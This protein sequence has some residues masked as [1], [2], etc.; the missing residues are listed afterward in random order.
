[1]GIHDLFCHHQTPSNGTAPHNSRCS[2]SM[3]RRSFSTIAVVLLLQ[4]IAVC[5]NVNATVN[6]QLEQ[7]QPQPSAS[8]LLTQ[9]DIIEPPPH[10][11]TGHHTSTSARLPTGGKNSLLDR[12][13]TLSIGKGGE[14]KQV[15]GPWHVNKAVNV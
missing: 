14:A 1:M 4:H 6:A 13:Q 9:F 3:S 10:D 7:Q 5:A 2:F 15:H 11:A 12:L 8:E